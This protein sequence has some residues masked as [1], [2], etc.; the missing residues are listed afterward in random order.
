MSSPTHERRDGIELLWPHTA[1]VPYDNRDGLLDA[2]TGWA[3]DGTPFSVRHVVGGGGIGKTRLAVELCRHLGTRGWAAS[4]YRH[5]ADPTDDKLSRL[6]TFPRPRMVVIDDS[7]LRT[8]QARETVARLYESGTQAQ[9]RIRVLLLGRTNPSYDAGDRDIDDLLRGMHCDVLSATFLDDAADRRAHFERAVDAFRETTGGVTAD[10][11]VRPDLSDD[12]FGRPLDVELAA[13]V[14]LHGGTVDADRLLARVVEIEDAYRWRRDECPPELRSEADDVTA[15]RQ[16][17]VAISGLIPT[18]EG[19]EQTEVVRLVL[20]EQLAATTDW[21]VG[22]YPDAARPACFQPV[23]PQLLAEH[24]VASME[25]QADPQTDP[26]TRAVRWWLDDHSLTAAADSLRLISLTMLDFPS[27]IERVRPSLQ[28]ALS[29]IVERLLQH[30][31]A[32][33]PATTSPD[34]VDYVDALSAVIRCDPELALPLPAFPESVPMY[35]A[36][37]DAEVLQAKVSIYTGLAAANPDQYNPDLAL[38]LNS[39]GVRLANLG[40]SDDSLRAAQHAVDIFIELTKTQPDR[41]RPSLASALN[42]LGQVFGQLERYDDSLPPAQHAASIYAE[43]ATINPDRYKPE[44]A[45]AYNS[46]GRTLNQLRRHGDAFPPAQHAV[47]LYRELAATDPDRHQPHLSSA[48]NN[49]GYILGRLE[50]WDEALATTQHAA[51]IYAELATADPDR[52]KPYVASV[53]IILGAGL[54]ELQRY[55]EALEP[56]QRAATLYIELATTNPDH[57]NPH[58][59]MTLNA[60]SNILGPLG[61]H[62]DALGAAQHAVDIYTELA[63][64]DPGRH[65]PD[66]AS[67]L[68]TLSVRRAALERYD[69][70]LDSAQRAV[71]IHTELASIDPVRHQPDLA[72][73]LIT[74]SNVLGFLGRD[75][76]ALPLTERATNIYTALVATHGDRYKPELA[77]ALNNLGIRLRALERYEGA[78]ESTQRAVDIRTELAATDPDRYNADLVKALRRLAYFHRKLGQ[79]RRAAK[80]ERQA[81][82]LS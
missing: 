78:L 29:E 53:G 38:A 21:L 50:R 71:D 59:A 30:V 3:D 79:P 75:D 35:V 66:L 54:G 49:L 64:I 31:Q 51:D 37:L 47:N 56:F 2:L 70:A 9:H 19:A 14:Q 7:D 48:L 43:L 28:A 45:A 18:G 82:K 39:L 13:L 65:Q 27:F 12:R 32:P 5:D 69:D 41:Y 17:L 11:D 25:Q 61:R 40:R 6:A 76:E 20:D 15:R 16:R 67:A 73:A 55:A 34:L 1:I 60:L 10:G 63:S 22:L 62:D 42:I 58:L 46:L 24:L 57:Y 74:A 80:A 23:Q 77:S 81:A 72:S 44:L 52:Y 36:N 33:R 4:F 8:T 26:L 68:N